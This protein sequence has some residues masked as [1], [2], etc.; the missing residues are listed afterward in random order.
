[1]ALATKQM[2][3]RNDYYGSRSRLG[4]WWVLTVLGCL[5][6]VL[7]PQLPWVT[8]PD[9]DGRM[10]INGFDSAT[11]ISAPADWQAQ[12][13]SLVPPPSDDSA[14]QDDG[15][16]SSPVIPSISNIPIAFGG[17]EASARW[18]IFLLVFGAIGLFSALWTATGEIERRRS[19]TH[20]VFAFEILALIPIIHEL[21][22]AKSAS[23]Y[24]AGQS[25]GVGIFIGLFG[26][27]VTIIGSAV[28]SWRLRAD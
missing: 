23:D 16:D 1:M 13:A 8:N 9:V 4:G 24:V 18:G 14:S 5:A 7:A 28:M 11:L 10:A 20:G 15:S 19:M 27:I 26:A 21:A 25:T 17:A 6:L 22:T 3:G 12:I 2:V